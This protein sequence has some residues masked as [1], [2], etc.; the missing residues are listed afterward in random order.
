[1]HLDTTGLTLPEVVD[2]I[3][4]M[5]TAVAGAGGD[6][7]SRPKVAVVGYPNVGKSSLVNRLSGGREAVV[8]ERAGVTR[9]R[10]DLPVRV[11]RAHVHAHRHRR[12]GR[13][14]HATRSPAR[15]ASRRR[16]RSPRPPSRVFV[17]D[18]RGG[19]AP[20][21]RG[22]RGHAAPRQHPRRR[23]RQQG[24]PR[25]GRPPGRRVPRARARRADAGLR[26]PGP[27][28][29]RPARP[30]RRAAAARGRGGRRGRR[31]HDPPRDHRAP[32]RRQVDASST[33]CSATSG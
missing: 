3:V 2:R 31:R 14:R 33:A 27:R 19:P 15:S 22:A 4:A 25:G 7:V 26:R 29:R 18:A 11:E 16:R 12:H 23:R 21:R 24:R 10:K 5:T 17:V 1:M 6:A 8:H 9:D 13:A 28:H 30:H 32:E 20:R